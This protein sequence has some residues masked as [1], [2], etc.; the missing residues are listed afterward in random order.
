MKKK[1]YMY[2]SL[3]RWN[4]IERIMEAFYSGKATIP[5]VVKG[6]GDWMVAEKLGSGIVTIRSKQSEQISCDLKAKKTHGFNSCI[7][8]SI[9]PLDI[10]SI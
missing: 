9:Y 1:S 2:I 3:D 6:G 10:P 7:V 5:L 8:I 4:K